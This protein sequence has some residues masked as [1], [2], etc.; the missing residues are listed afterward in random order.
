MGALFKFIAWVVANISRWGRAVAS[1]IGRIVAW[2]NA[3][4]KRV[5]GWINAGIS[6]GTIVE[7][8]LR[9]LGIG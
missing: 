1:H 7:W 5:L 4:A 2:I 9:A 8:I 6:F 3:N